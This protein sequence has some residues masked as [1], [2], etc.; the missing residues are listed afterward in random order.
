MIRREPPAPRL[1]AVVVGIILISV[2]TLYSVFPEF[3]RQLLVVRIAVVLIWAGTALI[4][5]LSA[6]T[7]EAR[8]QH[9]VE[10]RERERNELR[11]LASARV[12]SSLLGDAG[13]TIPKAYALSVYLYDVE[14]DLLVPV[15][16]PLT[17]DDSY[18]IFPPGVGATGRAWVE[19]DTIIADGDAVS[20][21]T[22]GLSPDQQAAFRPFHMVVA[23]PIPGED[24][25]LI[26][27]LTA[28]AR[29]RN[30]YFDSDEGLNELRSTAEVIGVVLDNLWGDPGTIET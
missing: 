6:S 21:E 17:G 3:G 15:H 8:V 22:F 24:G 12:V 30:D 5:V 19:R 14:Q 9:L 20:D 4:G 18:R 13:T 1:N 29:R 7:Q 27:V 28:I 11:M 26:G 16:P 2:P 10:H 23:T 25:R